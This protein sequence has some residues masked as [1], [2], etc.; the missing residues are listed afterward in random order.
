MANKDFNKIKTVKC[1][2]DM[3]N[4]FYSNGKEDM[5]KFEEDEIQFIEY[6]DTRTKRYANDRKFK[7]NYMSK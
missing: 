7:N 6:K 1:C 5:E 4:Q 2:V 3:Y